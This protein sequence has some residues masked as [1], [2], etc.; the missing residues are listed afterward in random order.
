MVCEKIEN[1]ENIDRS[2]E[3]NFDVISNSSEVSD[4]DSV[5]SNVS[6]DEIDNANEF[7]V[8]NRDSAKDGNLTLKDK[9]A[10]PTTC[11]DIIKGCITIT[12]LTLNIPALVDTGA[13]LYVHETL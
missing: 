7:H 2:Q 12:L 3:G 6:F 10:K 9:N 4:C 8:N 11:I 5:R 13:M 1:V